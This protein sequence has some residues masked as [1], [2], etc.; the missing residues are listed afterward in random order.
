MHKAESRELGE[1]K[2]RGSQYLSL[3]QPGYEL[4]KGWDLLAPTQE[5]E[6]AHSFGGGHCAPSVLCQMLGD[7]DPALPQGGTDEW[8]SHLTKRAAVLV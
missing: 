8:L 2:G 6:F 1:L 7:E 5:L 3:I 4:P